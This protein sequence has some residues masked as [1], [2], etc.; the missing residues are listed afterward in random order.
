VKLK[1]VIS[2]VLL[3]VYSLALVHTFI[4]H[5]HH[6]HSHFAETARVDMHDNDHES[7]H[8]HHFPHHDKSQHIG[9]YILNAKNLIL[10]WNSLSQPAIC[11]QIQI[12]DLS[13]A[14][15]DIK[16]QICYFVPPKIPHQYAEAVPLRAPPVI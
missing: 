9:D 6:T 8:N 16:N 1:V 15:R 13:C 3:A 12:F 4:P 14:A 5:D 11:R 10:H 7:N 2:Y